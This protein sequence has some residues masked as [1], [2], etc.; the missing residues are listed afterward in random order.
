MELSSKIYVAGHQGLVGSALC[1]ALDKAGYSNVIVQTP[2]QL[3]LRVQSDVEAFFWTEKPEYV[4]LAAARVG[5][6]KANIT[7]PAHFIYDNILIA[8][9]VIN[10]AYL[11]DTKKL[12][13]FGSSCLY[14]R[15]C[16][17]PIKE[18]Y[19]LTG[20]L[21]ETNRPYALAKIAGMEL[22][23]AYNKQ[24][25][26]Q[27]ITCMPT[28][29]YGSHDNFDI[30]SAHVIPALIAKIV[31]AHEVSA[32]H[33]ALW[34]TGRAI[35]EFLYVDDCVDAALFLMNSYEDYKTPLNIG[36]GEGCTIAQL[37][38]MIAHIIGYTGAFIF[39]GQ[40]EGTH[41]KVLDVTRIH[42]LGWRAHISLEEGL[43]KTIAWYYEQKNSG[44][45]AYRITP[46]MKTE[47]TS[48]HDL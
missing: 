5:G 39:D 18:S 2:Q 9:H 12:L 35:R 17:Q 16:A 48:L 34:G 22:C 31:K 32:P 33:V 20:P 8:A 46:C 21:E 25:G 36:T 40:L 19:L 28:N 43:K 41:C 38:L 6:I 13:F 45:E 26:T 47:F 4:F 29:L 44:I 42:N 7:Y 1:R 30:E 14:P 37:A 23:N 10:S 11:H 27:F 15:D 3:D 24:Y